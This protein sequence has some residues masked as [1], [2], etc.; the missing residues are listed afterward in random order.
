VAF[1]SNGVSW[2]ITIDAIPGL[3]MRQQIVGIYIKCKLLS[4]GKLG[5]HKQP[6]RS[7]QILESAGKNHR[8]AD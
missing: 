6:A 5:C 7:M 2:L 4:H 8:S 1:R 3:A